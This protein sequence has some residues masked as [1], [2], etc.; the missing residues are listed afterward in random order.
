MGAKSVN[1]A[2]SRPSPS[3]PTTET[4]TDALLE[5]IAWLMDNSIGIPGTRFRLGIDALLGLLPGAG[6][7]V[8]AVIQTGLVFLAVTRY[9]VPR[10]VAAR[11]A[12]NVLVDMG[13][14]SVP[15]IGDLFDVGFKANSR[16]LRLLKQVQAQAPES[17]ERERLSKSSR[18]YLLA[19]GAALGV[20][21]MLLL[22]G[23][24]ALGVWL[25][26]VLSRTA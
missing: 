23:T 6:D 20:G 25:F 8:S 13:L 7:F 10:S 17:L 24:I 11:M 2:R 4:G 15:L 12:A 26:S 3:Q 1:I 16:N 18:N 5:R 21:L 14:G 19:L 22:V 9:K